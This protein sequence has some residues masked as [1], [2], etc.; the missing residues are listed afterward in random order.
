MTF[1]QTSNKKPLIGLVL[2][3]VFGL[4]IT[5]LFFSIR[6]CQGTGFFRSAKSSDANYVYQVYPASAKGVE[7]FISVEGVFKTSIYEQ[8]GGFTMRSGS[9]EVRLSLHTLNKGELIKREVLGNLS[10]MNSSIIGTRDTVFWM[11]NAKDGIHERSVTDLNII[12]S[13]ENLIAKNDLLKEGLAKVNDNLG[14]LNELY[15]FD[16]EQNALMVTTVSGKNIWLD[17]SSFKTIA[18]IEIHPKN[19]YNSIIDKTIEQAISGQP[20]DVNQLT[21]EILQATTNATASFNLNHTSN[22]VVGF[23]SCTYT[24]E[25]TTLRTIKKTLCP[26]PIVKNTTTENSPFIEPA[27]IAAYNAETKT[28][29][30]PPFLNPE[31]SLILHAKTLGD[32][33]ELLLSSI[34]N[35]TIQKQF[36]LPTGII[37]SN[38][39]AS[40]KVNAVFGSGDT[41][42]LGIDN[43][44]FNINIKTGK[45]IWKKIIAKNDYYSQIYSTALSSQNNKKYIQ[46]VSS[47]YTVLSQQGI[48]VNGR[49]DY[50]QL[51]IDVN[52]GKIV[53][54][55]DFKNSA[56]ELIPYYL[57]NVHDKNWYYDYTNGLHTRTLP[58][59]TIA[60][61]NFAAALKTAGITSPLVKTTGYDRAIEDKYIGMDIGKKQFYFTT[62][63]GLHYSYDLN[64]NKITEIKAPEDEFYM[65]LRMSNPYLSNFYRAAGY[66]TQN[67]ML[68]PGG[69][70]LKISN[71][72]NISSITRVAAKKENNPTTVISGNQFIE[73]QFLVNG[74]SLNKDVY[75]TDRNYSPVGTTNKEPVLYIWHKNKIAEDAHR[76]ISKYNYNTENNLWQFDVT[77]LLGIDG[78]IT[79]VYNR[80]SSLVI[81]FKT[82]PNLDDNFTCVSINSDTGNMEWVFKF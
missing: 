20:I 21:Q 53:K 59:L 54:Q 48:F 71:Q 76:I 61:N 62:E 12:L 10:D 36:T 50:Q 28:V 69:D 43:Q 5:V 27:L 47:Y 11:Y 80:K 41:L 42:L 56:P 7:Y 45:L 33:S 74:I 34:N 4:V 37:L 77:A 25:G 19:D 78:E 55:Q 32:K 39:R 1:Y 18:P 66:S 24:F 8:K 30:N 35:K 82:H 16:K 49:T 31:Q 6:S 58:G 81:I 2:L 14:N 60:E 65:Q 44:L 70:L 40:Y 38:H 64:N 26:Q 52:T 22:T 46:V 75:Y 72:N 51:V 23:D 73:G 29:I 67:T 9:T 63:N 17:G 68:L 3:V 13:Q 79:R 57:G 15:A